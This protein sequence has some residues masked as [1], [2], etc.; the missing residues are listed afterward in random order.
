[1]KDD[2]QWLDN[3]KFDALIGFPNDVL[4]IKVTGPVKWFGD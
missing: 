4:D 1:M 2:Y 3:E